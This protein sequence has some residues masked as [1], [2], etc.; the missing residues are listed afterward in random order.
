MREYD[1]VQYLVVDS[2]FSSSCVLVSDL[3]VLEIDQH[4]H[5]ATLA[6]SISR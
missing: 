2:N 1:A 3:F 4:R 5:A 6:I